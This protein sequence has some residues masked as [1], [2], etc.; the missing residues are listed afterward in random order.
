[1]DTD[2]ASTDD[3]SSDEAYSLSDD[4][5]G[6]I[7]HLVLHVKTIGSDKTQNC[8]SGKMISS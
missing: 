1:M 2:D 6:S 7:I 8:L 3:D 4:E 5:Q